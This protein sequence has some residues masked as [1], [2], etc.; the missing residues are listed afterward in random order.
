MFSYI[1]TF[2]RRLPKKLYN[3]AIKKNAYN[4]I[5]NGRVFGTSDLVNCERKPQ[6]NLS[7]FSGSFKCELIE[8]FYGHEVV[9]VKIEK[10]KE[11]ST[12]R[13]QFL[14]KYHKT[15]LKF[16]KTYFTN[17]ANSRAYQENWKKP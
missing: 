9:K 12:K 3:S 13:F 17:Y 16:D 7:N 14:K 4:L 10:Y 2:I 8:S 5:T 6:T 15:P 11:I 1:Y